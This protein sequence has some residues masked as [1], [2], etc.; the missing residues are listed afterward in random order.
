MR[1]FTSSPGTTL[2]LALAAQSCATAA[3]PAL[4]LAP[5]EPPRGAPRPRTTISLGESFGPITPR[6]IAQA[7]EGRGAWVAS[8]AY[9]AVWLP[10]APAGFAPYVTHGGWT[11]TDAGWFWQSTLPWGD[12]TFHYGRWIPWGASWAWVPGTQFA[13]AWVDWRAGRGWVA[14]APRAPQ[15]AAAT[16]PF[17]YCPATRALSPRVA[18]AVVQGAAASSLYPQTVP[19]P[20]RQGYLGAVYSPG[21]PGLGVDAVRPLAS[22]GQASPPPVEVARLEGPSLEGETLVSAPLDVAEVPVAQ[23]NPREVEALVDARSPVRIRAEDLGREGAARVSVVSV[24]YGAR[25]ELFRP[26]R[27]EPRAAPPPP[28]EAL[29][30][31]EPPPLPPP[32][33]RPLAWWPRG[34][35]RGGVRLGAPPRVA[36]SPVSL[37]LGPPTA[38]LIGMAAPPPPAGVVVNTGGGVAGRGVAVTPAPTAFSA[39]P[40]S[41]AR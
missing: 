36:M 21:P 40:L 27:P 5:D 9:G 39:Q 28:P 8:P 7:T 4:A 10:A 33:D 34:R 6:A 1:A 25:A 31:D 3:P 26:R 30:D 12:L 19:V 13:P 20:P 37:P 38:P 18:R 41:S 23:V 24:P 17:V 16:A 35:S 22:V 32:A 15:G 11:V 29:R 14:W 2:L